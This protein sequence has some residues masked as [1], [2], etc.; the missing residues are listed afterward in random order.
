[1]ADTDPLWKTPEDAWNEITARPGPC[2][3]PFVAVEDFREFW[4][5]GYDW[6]DEDG[7]VPKRKEESQLP[8]AKAGGLSL[9]LSR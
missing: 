6:T 7:W 2:A 8:P 9:T 1:M 3:S 5:K 4:V